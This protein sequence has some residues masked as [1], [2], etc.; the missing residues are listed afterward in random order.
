MS[1]ISFDGKAVIPGGRVGYSREY[2]TSEDG[3]IIG[4]IFAVNLRGRL[5]ADKG[6][7][8]SSGTFWTVA[9][10]PPD[11]TIVADSR[12]GSLIRKQEALRGLFD[13]ANDGKTFIVQPWDGAAPLKCNPRIKGVEFAEGDWF[14]WCEYVVRMEA[15]VIYVNGALQGEDSFAD[16][17]SRA[18]ENWSIEPDEKEISYRLTH[19]VSA[20]GKRFYDEA[21]DLEKEAWEHAKS[22][23]ESRLGLD[24]TFMVCSGVLNE[25]NLRAFDYKRAQNTDQKGGVFQVTES[26]TCFANGNDPPALHDYTVDAVSQEDFTTR[27]TVQGRI[28]G[29][30]TRDNTTR[31]LTRSRINNAVDYYNNVVV[32]GVY[33]WATQYSGVESGAL[34]GT[35]LTSRFGANQNAGAVTYEYVFVDKPNFI[36]SDVL[37]EVVTVVE[38]NQANIFAAVPVLGRTAGPVLQSISTLT[39]KRRHLSIEIQKQAQRYGHT[40]T[41][42]DTDAIVALNVPGSYTQLFIERDSESWSVSRGQYSR[43]LTWVYE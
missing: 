5:V 21:G 34:A 2:Q 32:S 22:H 30:E 1:V 15:D 42:P 20:V 16:K 43:N 40:P 3:A 23:V 38:E 31:A 7:P 24:S 26:W 4:S 19:T 11:E 29:L 8:D 37:S 17:I 12:L 28:D 18:S 10:Y 9:G 13:S 14:D 41:A 25:S 33:I 39:A 35:F 6:S 36:T 27:V